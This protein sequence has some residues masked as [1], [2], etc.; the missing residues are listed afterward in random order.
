MQF[1]LSSTQPTDPLK[2]FLSAVLRIDRAHINT[3]M[4]RLATFD[5]EVT[6]NGRQMMPD[7]LIKTM[8]ASKDREVER[9]QHALLQASATN[10]GAVAAPVEV[11]PAVVPTPEPI[12]VAPVLPV[13]NDALDVTTTGDLVIFKK[14]AFKAFYENIHRGV[15]TMSHILE[16]R[17]YDTPR[18]TDYKDSL[19]KLLMVENSFQAAGKMLARVRNDI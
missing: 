18:R 13:I 16:S 3:H 17:M 15:E 14:R 5:I 9:L 10:T 8:L 7:V 2:D 1:D 6:V 4:E 11:A 19:S 12:P